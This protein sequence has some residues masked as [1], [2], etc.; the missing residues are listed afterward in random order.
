MADTPY[1]SVIIA[2]RDRPD[3]FVR[4]LASVINQSLKN[5]E[6]IAVIDGSKPEN[7]IRYRE[8]ESRYPEVRF[9]SLAQ[10]ECGHGHS[11]SM[12]R[13][14]NASSANYLG[15]LDDDD[16]WTDEDYLAR[17][18]HSIT[19]SPTS[20]DVYYSNQ[21]AMSHDGV[22]KSEDIWLSDLICRIESQRKH[23]SDSYF[24]DIDFLLSSKGFAHLNCSIFSREFYN[25]IGGMDETIRYE[26]DRDI[27]IRS[28]DAA[29]TILFSPS[30]IG[31]HNVP[32]RSTRTNL[33]TSY[34][35]IERKLFQIRVFDKGISNCQSE[36][37]VRYCI[38]AKTHELKHAA[39]IHAVKERYRSAAHYA[40]IALVSGFNF[41]WLAFTIYLVFMSHCRT[42]GP[43]DQ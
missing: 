12:N 11:Y 34:S 1:F 7:L 28:V 22:T 33:S 38:L 39:Q 2:T 5:K 18:F 16:Y 9:I 19:H 43:S 23:I 37:A 10:T 17:V 25:S 42:Q 3:L 29:K 20:V 6:V 41:R 21:I 4:A 40:K 8:I 27:Y 24:V 15:F 36:K 30:R 14:V 26:E 35:S 31:L 13:G 32:D